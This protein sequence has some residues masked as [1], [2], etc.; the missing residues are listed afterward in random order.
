VAEVPRTG[1]EP[2][3]LLTG[4]AGLLR[5]VSDPFGQA[6]HGLP[7]VPC[8]KFSRRWRFLRVRGPSGRRLRTAARNQIREL[9]RTSRVQL[10]RTRVK[11]IRQI[12]WRPPRAVHLKK[13]APRGGYGSQLTVTDG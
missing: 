6:D 1:L 3:R 7:A 10:V 12:E 4:R 5:L 8:V 13:T 11:V 9:V 2:V